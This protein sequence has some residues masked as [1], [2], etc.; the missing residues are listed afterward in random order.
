MVF[1]NDQPSFARQ[2]AMREIAKVAMTRLHFSRGLRKAELGRSRGT[3]MEEMPEPGSICYYFRAQKYNSNA[4]SKK[5]L[6]LKRWHGPALMVAIEGG[7][8]YL[9]HKGHLT[10]CAT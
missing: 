4:A 2:I 5:K 1:I 9:S 6:L 7:N 3:T 8:C 10:K